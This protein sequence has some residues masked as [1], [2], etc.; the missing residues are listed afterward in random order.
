MV[1]YVVVCRYSCV[2]V[3]N[4]GLLYHI[5]GVCKSCPL[6]LA[7]GLLQSPI[8]HLRW[9]AKEEKRFLRGRP[10]PRQRAAPFAIPLFVCS[11]RLC[12]S[13]DSSPRACEESRSA[14][15]ASW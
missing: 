3:I 5:L 7:P 4:D 15:S 12:N 11:S 14:P 9:R 10:A 8:C 6:H 2:K 13:P 1:G